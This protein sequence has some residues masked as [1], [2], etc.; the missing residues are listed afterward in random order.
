[1]VYAANITVVINWNTSTNAASC[2]GD[3]GC[4]IEEYATII[5]TN[6]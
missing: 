2:C 5:A 3:N 1:M 4:G 6:E